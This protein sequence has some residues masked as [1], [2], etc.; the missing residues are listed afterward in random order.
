MSFGPHRRI[1]VDPRYS[2]AFDWALVLITPLAKVVV[3]SEAVDAAGVVDEGPPPLLDEAGIAK[4]HFR[5]SSIASLSES[6]PLERM[7]VPHATSRLEA[8]V[9]PQTQLK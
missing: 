1:W 4:P 8:S 2:R 7:Q 9:D 5:A 6:P 3:E